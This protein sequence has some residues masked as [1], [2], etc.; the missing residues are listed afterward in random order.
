MPGF[1]HRLQHAPASNLGADARV[2]R[3]MGGD[4]AVPDFSTLSWRS[5]GLVLPSVR[6]QA[7]STEPVH[8]V[9][10]STGLKVFGAGEWLE[11]KHKV[12]AKRKSWRKLHFGLDLVSGEIIGSNLTTDDIGDPTALPGLL[13]QISGSV[14]QFIVNG[15]Y[16]RAPS[17]D[18]LDT[19][20]GANLEVIIP[21]PKIADLSLKMGRWKTVSG[22]KFKVKNLDN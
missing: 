7:A 1:T 3:L 18:P 8:L 13:E 10:D 12:K 22:P 15:A 17:S 9:V 16:D 11:N 21:V 14:A 19:R 6:R 20:F 2:A 5:K 4:I